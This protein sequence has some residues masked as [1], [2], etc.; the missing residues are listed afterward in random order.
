MNKS[1]LTSPPITEAVIDLRVVAS[2][3]ADANKL[4][5]AHKEIMDTFPD[6]HPIH[7]FENNFEFMRG[8]QKLS[9]KQQHTGFR[10]DSADKKRVVQFRLDG[11]SYSHFATYPG[12]DN[13]MKEA[14][15]LWG[16][17]LKNAMPKE[18]CRVAVRTINKIRFDCSLTEIKK[19]INILPSLP[20]NLASQESFAIQ[21]QLTSPDSIKSVITEKVTPGEFPIATSV[22]F[23]LDVF[24]D[25]VSLS[26]DKTDILWDYFEK[27]REVKN[28]IFFSSFTAKAS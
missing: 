16:V 11:F 10:F 1:N 7:V 17:Y 3:N 2:E 25:K 13:V 6:I 27:I 24:A 22:V 4:E 9:S 21:V 23:D 14:K 28:E 19:Y 12:W 20:D 8:K 18:V 26:I 5:S 15:S